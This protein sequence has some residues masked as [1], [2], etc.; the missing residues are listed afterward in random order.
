MKTC[1][2]CGTKHNN[3][4]W[5]GYC[6]INC[7]ISHRREYDLECE[8]LEEQALEKQRSKLRHT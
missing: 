3:Q 1:P 6:D 2:Y 5:S 7:V 8:A 4:G